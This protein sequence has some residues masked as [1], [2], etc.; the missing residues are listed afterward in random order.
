M[1]RQVHSIARQK[2]WIQE[3]IDEAI[4]GRTAI[5]I[6][7]RLSTIKHA[8]TIIVLKD[9]RKEEEGTLQELLDRKGVFFQLWE[10]Q[11]F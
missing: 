2:S 1:K 7:H 6:A 3:A 8:D 10:E 4:A 11:K 9:G 5:V